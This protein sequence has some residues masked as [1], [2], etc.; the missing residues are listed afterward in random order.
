MEGTGTHTCAGTPGCQI[1]PQAPL[2]ASDHSDQGSLQ[3]LSPSSPCYRQR[4][5]RGRGQ[6][7]ACSLLRSQQLASQALSSEARSYLPNLQEL[8]LRLS[9]AANTIPG[10]AAELA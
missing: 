1:G 9:A 2:V 5:A 10:T 4:V 8:L 3:R 6:R 7:R